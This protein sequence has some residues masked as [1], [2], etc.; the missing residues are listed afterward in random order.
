[1]FLNFEESKKLEASN[2]ISGISFPP[3]FFELT[4]RNTIFHFWADSRSA[5]TNGLRKIY[6]LP[7]I[8]ECFTVIDVDELRNMTR[9]KRTSLSS[10]RR[11]GSA[12]M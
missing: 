5:Q 12:K 3:G 6:I 1:M 2:V 11:L 10:K 9:S 8:Y 7:T 4:G